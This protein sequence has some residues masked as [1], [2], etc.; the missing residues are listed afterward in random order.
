MKGYEN[1]YHGFVHNHLISNSEYYNIKAK[2]ALDRYFDNISREIKILEFGCGLGQN[3]YLLNEAIGYDISEFALNFCKDKNVN[4]IDNLDNV[5]DFDV[6]FS[7]HVLEHVENPSETLKIMRDK[8][9]I[10]GKL[11]LILPTEKQEKVKI[12]L[13]EHQHLYCWN[14]KSI[15]NLLIKNG[16][17]IIENKFLRGAGYNKLLFVNK[18][19]FKL[20]K[21]LTYIVGLIFGRKELKITAIKE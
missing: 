12:K 17:S 16:F 7:S 11:I 9:R 4:V 13:D 10:G 2:L 5:D 3:I 6:V 21:S 15:N 18:I 14:F 19:N 8:L 1:E 20:Y